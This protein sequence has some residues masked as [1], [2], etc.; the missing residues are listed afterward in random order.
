MNTP[1]GRLLCGS[2]TRHIRPT[3]LVVLLSLLAEPGHAQDQVRTIDLDEAIRLAVERHPAS[4]QA[5]EQVSRSEADLLQARGSLLPTFNAQAFYGNSSNQRVDQTTGRLVSESYT[6]QLTGSYE[7]FGGGRRFAQL[8]STG[9]SLDAA[10]ARYRAQRFQAALTTTELF[11]AAAAGEDILAAAEQRLERARQQLE[12]ARTRLELGTATTSDALRAEIEVGNAE[13]AVVDARSTVRRARLELARQIGEESPVRP[14]ESS[15]PEHAPELP[16]TDQLVARAMGESPTVVAA[17]ATHRSSS[18]LK[19]VAWTPYLPSL[20]L[21]GGVD[22][23]AFDFPPDTRSWSLRVTASLPLFDG[24]QREATLARARSQERVAAALARDAQIGVRVAVETAV[25]EIEAASRG[26]T[27]SQ[28]SLVLARE[29]LRVQEE[30]YQIG[31]STILELQASQ[32]AL[33]EAEVAVV[34]AQEAL[35]SAVARLEAILGE[36]LGGA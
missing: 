31:A 36:P 6:T 26:V 35:G 19:R 28:R 17:E 33:S 2:S 11:Y 23:F 22:W 18:A 16:P 3:A 29:D 25:Q 27:I 30:R 1:W 5:A 4:V 13:L 7:L 9:A 24:F 20:R 21:S 12:F 8:R 15:L 14:A 34:R 32:I 10:E